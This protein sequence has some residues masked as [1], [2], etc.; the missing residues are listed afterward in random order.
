MKTKLPTLSLRC[1]SMAC[2]AILAGTLFPAMAHADT[3]TLK[4]SGSWSVSSNWSPNGIPSGEG[5]VIKRTEG[6]ATLVQDIAGGVTV[7]SIENAGTASFNITATQGI[8]F[9]QDGSGSGAASI[10]N[11]GTVAGARI[12]FNSGG[13]LTLADDLN[14]TNNNSASA[15]GIYA[16]SP[17]S[18]RILSSIGGSGNITIN[19][20]LNDLNYGAVVMSCA[21]STFTGNVTIASGL[22]AFD[23]NTVFGT[24]SNTVYLGVT[25]G[26]SVTL[27]SSTT[28]STIPA[29]ANNI[30]VAA[31]A[32]TAV[33]GSVITTGTITTNYSGNITL[34]GNLTLTSQMVQTTGTCGV[35]LSGTV[36]GNGGLLVNGTFTSSGTAL[37][38]TGAVKLTNANTFTGDTRIVAG[39]LYVANTLALQNSTVDMNASD[40]GTLAFGY[41]A[42]TGQSTA[43]LGGLTGSRDLALQDTTGAAVALSIGNNNASTSY[44]GNLSGAGSLTKIGTGKLTL[45]GNNSYTGDTTVSAGELS[46]NGSLA[47][48]SKV[49]VNAG[50]T[51][52]GS[53]TVGG[54]VAVTSGTVNGNGLHLGVTTF[55]GAS[56]LSGSTVATSITVKTGRLSLTG[57]TQSSLGVNVQATL[58]NTGK[59]IGDTN[60]S[61]TLSGN[62]TING[63][64]SILNGGN[65][66][67]SSAG[68][69]QHVEGS[70]SVANGGTLSVSIGATTSPVV[71]S[72]ESSTISLDTGSILNIDLQVSLTSSVTLVDNLTANLITT[73]F[74]EVSI[75]GNTYNVSTSNIFTDTT[76]IEY[77]LSYTATADSDGIA[78]DIAL[79][80]VPEPSTWAL[81]FG[82]CGT[83]ALFQRRKRAVNV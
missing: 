22:T 58:A 3:F 57:T 60:V 40:A 70:L 49:N 80:V 17:G 19:N 23:R 1:R 64:L 41:S 68:G 30:V 5:V 62:G 18:I 31:T 29:L 74:S 39:T 28:S 65:L 12:N 11:S 66:V 26:S 75:N 55:D 27:V 63:T 81:V 21:N 82:G 71:V 54:T 10:I 13:T 2:I 15:N 67:A 35:V 56:T 34:N 51:L 77:Q 72:G 36:S 76:G 7:G 24:T 25:G 45:S 16:T 52:S 48:G 42:T 43:T 14:I 9:N 69:A 20:V 8:T 4:A 79:S 59:V 73:R 83:L 46:V 78:N 61:G 37:T 32:G 38:T 47:A 6:S 44:T 33:L 50:T 53:G